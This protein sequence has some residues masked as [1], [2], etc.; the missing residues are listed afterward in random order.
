MELCF[1]F[2]FYYTSKLGLRIKLLG[3]QN[4]PNK[5]IIQKQLVL[6]VIFQVYSGKIL[7]Y[8]LPK[9]VQHYGKNKDTRGAISWGKWDLS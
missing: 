7:V 2:P 1:Q 3:F 9:Q 8:V 4:N 6:V 5:F